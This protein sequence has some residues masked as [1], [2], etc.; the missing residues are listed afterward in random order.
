MSKT[1]K[2]FDYQTIKMVKGDKLPFNPHVVIVLDHWT[3][4]GD[5]PPIIS[6]QL[7]SEREIDEYVQQLKV[8]L[9]AVAKTAKAALSRAKDEAKTI[10]SNRT[11]N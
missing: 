9:D 2:Q 7:M 8:D 1:I 6:P 5:G 10:V 4:N 3:S 11:S